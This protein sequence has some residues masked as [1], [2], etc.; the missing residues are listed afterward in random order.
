LVV[1]GSRDYETGVATYS[2]GV[3]LQDKVVIHR[4]R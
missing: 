3:P 1:W 2:P 4:L